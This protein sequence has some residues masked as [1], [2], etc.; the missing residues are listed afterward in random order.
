MPNRTPSPQQSAEIQRLVDDLGPP[1]GEEWHPGDWPT[2]VCREELGALPLVAN[3][4]FTW[5]LRPDGTVLR[6]DRDSLFHPTEPETDPLAVYAVLEQSP[7]LLP[8]VPHPPAGTR[9]CARCGG[10]GVYD[11]TVGEGSRTV[12]CPR[13]DGFGW[14]IVPPPSAVP[15]S[16]P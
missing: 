13:C 16:P 10:A 6:M 15:P 12:L 1:P 3:L 11:E 7:A 9:R 5:A 4:I 8:L 14:I 2:R